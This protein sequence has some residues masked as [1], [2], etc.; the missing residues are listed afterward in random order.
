M[1]ETITSY[2]VY[3]ALYHVVQESSNGRD[4][5]YEPPVPEHPDKCVYAYNGEPSCGV[6]KA[7]AVLGV[8]LDVLTIL[9]T[10]SPLNGGPLAAGSDYFT[11][12]LERK[13][14][15]LTH[16][17]HDVLSRFQYQQDRARTWGEALDYARSSPVISY[18]NEG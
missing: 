6:G 12:N 18:E 7:L 13:G 15:R 17:A 2:Q 5:V 14:F 10:S 8:P 9:D 3:T 16:A 4:T 1:T 11:W